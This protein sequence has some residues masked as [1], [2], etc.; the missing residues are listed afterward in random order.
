MGNLLG[1]DKYRGNGNKNRMYPHRWITLPY[2]FATGLHFY[3]LKKHRYSILM[4]LI[5][6]WKWQ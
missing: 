1:L 2:L 6:S 4:A 3:F 5:G